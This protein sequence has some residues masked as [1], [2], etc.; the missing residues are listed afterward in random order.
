M[1]ATFLAAAVPLTKTFTIEDGQLKKTSHPRIIDCSSY[2][3]EFETIEDLYNCIQAH[4]EAGHCFLKGSVTRQLVTESRAGATNLNEATRVLLLD[5]DGLRSVADVEAFLAQLRLNIVDYI[6]QYSSSMGVVPERGISAHIYILLDK[7]WFPAMLK[8]WLIHANITNYALRQNLGLTRTCNALRWALD[9]STCQNDKLIYIAPPILGE[10]VVDHFKGERIQLVKKQKRY[11]ELEALGPIPSAEA[12]KIASETALNELREKAGL[13]KRKRITYKSEGQTEYMVKPDQAVVTGVRK[14]RGFVYLNLNNGD[15]WGYYHPEGN[16]EFI[17]NFKG[18]PIY[19]TSELAPDYW[20]EAKKDAAKPRFDPSG[21]LYLAFRDFRTASY[22]NGTWNK[23]TDKLELAQA[24]GTEQ[25]R[26]FLKQHEQP[27]GDYVPDWHLAFNPMDPVVVNVEGRTINTF[28]PTKYMRLEAHPGV[29]PPL[30]RRTILHALGGSEECF[31]Y[32]MNWMA[33]IL[34]YRCMAESAWVLHGRTG[35]GKGLF[36]NK[37]LRP[38]F[39]YVVSKRT[40]EFDSQ[41]N[42]FMEECLILWIDEA[43]IALAPGHHLIEQDLKNYIKEPV[44]SIR[45]MQMTAFQARNYMSLILASNKKEIVT[46][47]SDDRRFNVAPFQTQELIVTPHEVDFGF[48]EELEEFARY[49]LA[50]PA[51]RQRCRVPLR[52]EAKDKMTHLS[53]TA[54]EVVCN[55]LLE[56]NFPF[57]W[58][59]RPMQHLK[60]GSGNTSADIAGG[61]YLRLMG[62]IARGNR[63]VL[64]REEVQD[65]LA[66]TV[67]SIPASPVKFSSTI[68]HHGIILVSTS[69]EGR[70]VR[71]MKVEWKVDEELKKEVLSK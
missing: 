7:P 27:I 43:E 50:Y 21:V 56:G 63:Q 55:A 59:Q 17:H 26:D 67:G 25:L 58:E 71:G 9:V 35:T 33:V 20:T 64:L 48:D 53:Q 19:K 28:Q 4:A 5:L 44:I 39:R 11:V 42:A 6:V 49:L 22:W 65:I 32:M 46:L 36:L 57:L 40:R 45:R 2:E 54:M 38:L 1:K 24:K 14:E 13:P 23:G 70:S 18:E 60:E 15:S 8:Q 37:I 61:R 29:I 47:A 41:F 34:Q 66:W 31:D 62:E 16:A 30:I 52:N 69:R 12:N 68:K 3:H 10:G 51:D